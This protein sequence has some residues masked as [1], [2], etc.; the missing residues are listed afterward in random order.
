MTTF[1]KKKKKTNATE[2][3]KQL[4]PTL[5]DHILARQ[6]MTTLRKKHNKQAQL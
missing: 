6:S 2:E 3:T 1:E 4:I 5:E